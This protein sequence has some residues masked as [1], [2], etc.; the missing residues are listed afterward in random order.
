MTTRFRNPAA[1]GRVRTFALATTLALSLIMPTAVAVRADAGVT[2]QQASTASFTVDTANGLA[3]LT[4]VITGGGTGGVNLRSDPAHDAKVLATLQDGTTVALRIDNVDT[5]VD[6]DGVT[7]WWPVTANGQDGWVSGVYLAA[8]GSTQPNAASTTPTSVTT[9]AATVVPTKVSSTTTPAANG[10]PSDSRG[11]FQLQSPDIVGQTAVVSA[12]GQG[13]HLRAEASN[14]SQSLA[15]LPDGTVVNL[16]IDQVDTIVDSNGVRWWPVSVNGQDGWIS[17][18]YLINS[19]SSSTATP[20][21]GTTFAV[22]TYAAVKTKS[23]DGL[24]IRADASPTASVLT[25]IPDGTVVQIMAGPASHDNSTNGWYLITVNGTTG[26]ADG[27]LL[28]PAS[29]PNIPAPTATAQKPAFKIGDKVTVTTDTKNGLN[30][31][32]HAL[33]TANKIGLVPEGTTLTI[34]NGPSSFN[35]STAGWYKIT[36]NGVTGFVNGDYLTLAASAPATT[37]PAVTATAAAQTP[38]AAPTQAA[39]APAFA[40]DDYVAVKTASGVGANVRINAAMSASKVGYLADGSIVQVTDGPKNDTQGNPWYQVT[41]GANVNGWVLGSLLIASAAPQQPSQ[42]A[43]SAQGFIWP[44]DGGTVTQGFGCSYLGFY[45]YD[46]A[47]GCPVHDGLDIA[48]PSYTPIHA[49]AAGT[50]VAA[51]W[52]D[53]GLGYYVEIDHGNG[54]HTLYGHMAEQPYVSVGQQ[55]SQGETIGPVGAT[56]LATGPHVH[57]MVKINGVAQDPQQYL[58]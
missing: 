5:V 19:G 52:C 36:Y 31:R 49:A 35:Q 2:T 57:F 55:V 21:S 3:G 28:I 39:S 12:A 22:G 51:G 9:P 40:K 43:V 26:Y 45:A 7:R 32:D 20:A 15:S 8:S 54:V 38:T 1:R 18:Y 6:P 17:G 34:E 33:P 50:V 44:I 53:C 48:A 29:Q 13:V 30:I 14:D 58:P 46:P 10:V 11:A 23:G 4:A 37:T 41:D 25:T 24:N 27:D 47:W 42:P 16:R 56:G